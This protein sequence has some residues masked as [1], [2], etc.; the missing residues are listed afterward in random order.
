MVRF[1]REL[2]EKDKNMAR[3]QKSMQVLTGKADAADKKS[4]D[5]EM[6]LR[7]VQDELQEKD[8]MLKQHKGD[9]ANL[10]LRL[11][12]ATESLENMTQI[13]Q[14]KLMEKDMDMD[15]IRQEQQDKFE[16]MLIEN[17]RMREQLQSEASR[18]GNRHEVQLKWLE[19]LWSKRNEMSEDELREKRETIQMMSEDF[20]IQLGNIA[21]DCST[22]ELRFAKLIEEVKQLQAELAARTLALQERAEAAERF[23][24]QVEEKDGIIEKLLQEIEARK[25]QMDESQNEAVQIAHDTRDAALKELEDVRAEAK[26]KLTQEEEH[27]RELDMQLA[28]A[29]S[30][31]A[32]LQSLLASAEARIQIEAANLEAKQDCADA[33]VRRLE[34]EIEKERQR[35]KE[36]TGQRE[37]KQQQVRDQVTSLQQELMLR[38]KEAATARNQNEQLEKEIKRAH[39]SEKEAQ[40]M[41]Q[42]ERETSEEQSR[43][44]ADRRVQLRE[45]SDEVDD[46]IQQ[47]QSAAETNESLKKH[48]VVQEQHIQSLVEKLRSQAAEQKV[49]TAGMEQLEKE[50]QHTRKQLEKALHGNAENERNDRAALLKA[51]RIEAEADKLRA[52]H[53]AL[54]KQFKEMEVDLEERT[55][56][57]NLLKEMVHSARIAARGKA[58]RR[59]G[60][61][62]ARSQ[63]DADE[64]ILLPKGSPRSPRDRR[65]ISRQSS[66]DLPLMHPPLEPTPRLPDIRSR[67]HHYE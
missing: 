1:N 64:D 41:L 11:K 66:P 2:A 39:E 40:Q 38:T 12:T 65:L 8:Q 20:S 5:A 56:E 43:E 51:K 21:S 28:A 6:A 31:A 59:K 14:E 50:L 33:N 35:H 23:A 54:R 4:A 63:G 30:E 46:S 32:T 42:Q 61:N 24:A 55:Q 9:Q 25:K 57:C 47:L 34:E 17:S 49:Q 19:Y 60:G 44:L 58:A 62:K 53:K 22:W 37:T 16:A 67:Y 27:S 26:T 13:M 36:E 29:Q 7:R 15:H 18:I 45:L 52:A 3:M 48:M 10:E